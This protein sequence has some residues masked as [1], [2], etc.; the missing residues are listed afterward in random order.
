MQQFTVILDAGNFAQSFILE[1]YG[2]VGIKLLEIMGPSE[3]QTLLG[4]CTANCIF[5]ILTVIIVMCCFTI[6][7]TVADI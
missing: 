1:A 7:D 2:Y 5:Y 4:Y 3:Q 6:K